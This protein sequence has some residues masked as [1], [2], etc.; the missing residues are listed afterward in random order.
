MGDEMDELKT[1]V[2][3]IEMAVCGDRELGVTGLV[4]DVRT[5]KRR[6]D[7]LEDSQTRIKGGWMAIV[8]L[9]A[10]LAWLWSFVKDFFGKP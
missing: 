2:K 9:S 7:A 10:G 1:S 3:R 5:T 8:G 4:D 6:V